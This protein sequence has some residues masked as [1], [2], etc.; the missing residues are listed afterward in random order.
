MLTFTHIINPVS[1]P[2]TSD[3]F[4]AQPVT[5]ESMRRAKAYGADG[6]TVTQVTT[7]YEEDRDRIP[8]HLTVL[9]N[10][11]RSIMDVGTFQKQ[12]KLP[13]IQDILNAAVAADPSADYIIYTNVDIALLPHFYAFVHEQLQQGH[14]A[15]IINRRTISN[16]YD[17]DSLVSAYSA[18]GEK[19]PG[20]DCFVIPTACVAQLQLGDISIGAN[21]IGRAF[22]ANLVA[23]TQRP[24]IY[25][26][27]H[28]TF[29][30]GEDGAWLVSD[31]SE[32]DLHN[33]KELYA[34]MEALQA[35]SL[36]EEKQRILANIRNFM[37]GYGDTP[38]NN[39][40]NKPP[41]DPGFTTRTKKKIK[42]IIKILL[43]K[44]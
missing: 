11:E 33:K 37:D 32:F 20:Y 9:P 22:Y 29:H 3:L 7:Q 30:I 1:V 25:T 18:V 21:W 41:Y 13:L 27:E 28:V 5:F 4:V 44:E 26:D 40:P 8:N 34:I 15:L 42:K 16:E 17:L 23:V 14:D 39:A 36:S 10:L 43:N 19:H 2:P 12:R 31:F 6:F 35:R 38:T 24:K